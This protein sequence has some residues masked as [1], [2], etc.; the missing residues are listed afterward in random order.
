ME[1]NRLDKIP[2]RKSSRIASLYNESNYAKLKVSTHLANAISCGN[3]F[4]MLALEQIQ[5]AIADDQSPT[6]KTYYSSSLVTLSGN[7]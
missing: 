3:P 1:N 6:L 5:A 2:T 4:V 7:I